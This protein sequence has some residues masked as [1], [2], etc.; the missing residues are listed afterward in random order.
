MPSR[1]E[2]RSSTLD[3]SAYGMR[4]AVRCE[5]ATRTHDAILLPSRTGDL[6]HLEIGFGRAAVRAA[7]QSSGMSSHGC[8]GRWMRCAVRLSSGLFTG[9]SFDG[10]LTVHDKQRAD[11]RSHEPGDR[12]KIGRPLLFDPSTQWHA[13]AR[14]SPTR[15]DCRNWTSSRTTASAFPACSSRY[16]TSVAPPSNTSTAPT[17]HDCA[18][19][20]SRA[21]AHPLHPR[22][23]P[24]HTTRHPTDRPLRERLERHAVKALADRE[25]AT[26][27]TRPH[28]PAGSYEEVTR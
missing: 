25:A 21:R 23:H 20:A 11:R 14:P 7:F 27:H 16:S 13:G 9:H 3:A 22:Q 18:R 1:I 12:R 4:C 8:P 26:H 28:P 19:T 15:A 17:S 6:H 5:R 10:S 2:S 24:L